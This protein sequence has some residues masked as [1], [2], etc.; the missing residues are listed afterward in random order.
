MWDGSPIIR[1]VGSCTAQVQQDSLSF[2][3]KLLVSEGQGPTLMGRLW[4]DKLGYRLCKGGGTT[5]T[6][7]VCSTATESSDT[8]S[9]GSRQLEAWTTLP[10]ARRA[11]FPCFTD[12]LGIY[13]GD[14][15]HIPL[16]SD[17]VP[18]F[19]KARPVPIP[20]QI[21][22]SRKLDELER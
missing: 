15:V 17:A 8:P 5:N 22:V 14:P 9:V 11:Q 7:R 13:V 21:P 16:K 6:V 4:L 2:E 20:R 19:L 3:G 1:V 18:V 10:D 12:K